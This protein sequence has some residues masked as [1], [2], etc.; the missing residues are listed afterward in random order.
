[1]RRRAADVQSEKIDLVECGMESKREVLL[2]EKAPPAIGPYSLGIRTGELLFISGTL[3]MDPVKGEM[4]Q[5]GIEA[6]TRQALMN[7]EQILIAGG[8][9]LKHVVKTTVFMRDLAE[10]P[11]M[12]TIYAGFFPEDPPARSTVQVARLP[13]DAAVEIE[14]IALAA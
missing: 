14:A 6:E 8:S 2:A 5:G 11:V 9:S 12:N 7:L 4:V 1:M 3:G 13:K 10:F